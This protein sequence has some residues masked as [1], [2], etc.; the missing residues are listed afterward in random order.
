MLGMRTRVHRGKL[1]WRREFMA[2]SRA[3]VW[4]AESSGTDRPGRVRRSKCLAQAVLCS[5]R[6]VFEESGT[7]GCVGQDPCRRPL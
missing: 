7:I 6:V 3:G 1:L 5:V 2:G 4:L